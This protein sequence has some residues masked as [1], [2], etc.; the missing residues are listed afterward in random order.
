MKGKV[1]II[2]NEFLNFL[3]FGLES[4]SIP[5]SL[6][7]SEEPQEIA[8]DHPITPLVNGTEDIHINFADPEGNPAL[9]SKEIKTT[10]TYK[11]V[12]QSMKER[13]TPDLSFRRVKKSPETSYRQ[14]DDTDVY[15]RNKLWQLQKDSRRKQKSKEIERERFKE[16][17]FS[18]NISPLRVSGDNF[19]SFSNLTQTG[20]SKTMKQNDKKSY[21]K[22]HRVKCEHLRKKIEEEQPMLT[23]QLSLNQ[24]KKNNKSD[25]E[26]DI[27][28]LTKQLSELLYNQE[29]SG[30]NDIDFFN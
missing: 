6:K 22:L 16:C 19:F 23:Q 28:K 25:E 3:N 30:N 13:K 26:L 1:Q 17:S 5:N 2:Q 7:V 20:S 10:N 18:P 4:E 14:L 15:E 27:S 8:D 11:G 9:K 29:D 21:S 12:I 24:T